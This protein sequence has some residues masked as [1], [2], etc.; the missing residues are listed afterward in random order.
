MIENCLLRPLSNRAS[1]DVLSVKSSFLLTHGASVP[2]SAF[3]QQPSEGCGQ[4]SG[5][6]E[7]FPI[8]RSETSQL[9]QC[10]SFCGPHKACS[11]NLNTPFRQIS[12]AIDSIPEMKGVSQMSLVSQETVESLRNMG[13]GQKRRNDIGV[14][15]LCGEFEGRLCRKPLGLL[16]KGQR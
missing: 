2:H 1:A 14:G 6:V 12:M 9:H 7:H 11:S 5:M 8:H 3:E 13:G 4:N 15:R 16:P 10:L